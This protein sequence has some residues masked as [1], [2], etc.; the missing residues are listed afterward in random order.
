MVLKNAADYVPTVNA[1]ANNESVFA[2]S[3]PRR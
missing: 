3:G 2:I 1:R